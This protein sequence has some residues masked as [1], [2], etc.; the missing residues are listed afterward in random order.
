MRSEIGRLK[1]ILD[2]SLDLARPVQPDL[3]PC[4]LNRLAERV[5]RREPSTPPIRFALCADLPSVPADPDL[6]GQVLS[7]LLRTAREADAGDIEIATGR[8]PGEVWLCVR[9]SGTPIPEEVLGR[10]F[11]PFVTTKSSGAGVGLALC[12]K[13]VTAHGGTI[14]ARNGANGTEFE[15]TLPW[16]Y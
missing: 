1:R 3:V 16:T 4:N 9:N 12:K 6:I 8:R 7:N 5:G 11:Q 13:I 10:I 2:R 14:D 15:V